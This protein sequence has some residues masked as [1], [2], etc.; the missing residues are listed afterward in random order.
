MTTH[1]DDLHKEGITHTEMSLQDLQQLY[2]DGKITEPQ[3]TKI[4]IDNLGAKKFMEVMQATL[5]ETYGKDLLT[6]PIPE[7]LKVLCEEPKK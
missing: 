1:F 6:R 5:E 7:G 2:K 4:L 3:F